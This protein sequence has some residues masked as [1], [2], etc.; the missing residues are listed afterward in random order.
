MS[1]VKAR[2]YNQL[3]EDLDT[4]EGSKKVLKMVKQRDKNLKDIYQTKVIKSEEGNMLVKNMR[5]W[6]DGRHIS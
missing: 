4:A 3:C 1:V 6:R 5:S 2:T